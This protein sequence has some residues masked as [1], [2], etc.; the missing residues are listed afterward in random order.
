MSNILISC[1]QI[2]VVNIM[3][4]ILSFQARGGKTEEPSQGANLPPRPMTAAAF[5]A[6]GEYL[7]LSGRNNPASLAQGRSNIKRAADLGDTGALLEYGI[8]L[9]EG[10]GGR[11]STQEAM[12]HFERAAASD[13]SNVRVRRLAAYHL[14][15]LLYTSAASTRREIEI[16]TSWAKLS[17]LNH[18]VPALTLL[19]RIMQ[20]YWAAPPEKFLPFF[21]LAAKN[22]DKDAALALSLFFRAHPQYAATYLDQAEDALFRHPASD[23]RPGEGI[24]PIY[25]HEIL[26]ASEVSSRF[27][28]LAAAL[29]AFPG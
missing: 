22:R 16:A 28:E 10:I 12:I 2:T 1:R 26:L 24:E 5:R 29:G 8:L 18:Y 20:N 15:T 6:K 21:L 4:T 11:Q 23:V 27:L 3:I 19:G 14:A 17:A 25:D 7:I 13:H 9:A